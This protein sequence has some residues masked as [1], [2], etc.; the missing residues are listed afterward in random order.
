[1]TV[2]RVCGSGA[3]VPRLAHTWAL[4]AT[5]RRFGSVTVRV[6]VTS[7]ARL[8]KAGSFLAL[9]PPLRPVGERS[10]QMRSGQGILGVFV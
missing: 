9:R 8:T 6:P 2:E 7:R 4:Q 1:M 3:W 10:G 5:A